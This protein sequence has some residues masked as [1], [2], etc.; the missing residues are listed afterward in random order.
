VCFGKQ[1]HRHDDVTHH[2]YGQPCRTIVGVDLTEAFA[3]SDAPVDLL[4]IAFEE[5]AAAAS[6]YA[7]LLETVSAGAQEMR[8]VRGAASLLKSPLRYLPT[9][10]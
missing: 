10:V 3:A 9:V 2:G 7:I 1:R 4:W 8:I 6:T 5:L